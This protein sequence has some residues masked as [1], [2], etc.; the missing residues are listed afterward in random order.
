MIV[1]P[2]LLYGCDIWGFES[3]DIIERIH[4]KFL[5]YIFSLISSTLTYMVYEETGRFFLY[6]NDM[7]F[8]QVTFKS[9]EQKC[10]YFI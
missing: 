2:V 5:K 4:L 1:V 3:L 10:L 8:D 9:R 7:L 6:K